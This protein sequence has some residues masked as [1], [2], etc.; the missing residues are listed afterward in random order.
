MINY[1]GS[2]PRDQELVF[3]AGQL[4][5]VDRCGSRPITDVEPPLI[6][7]TFGRQLVHSGC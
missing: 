1:S 7:A 6:N 5:F 4:Q 2:R 3:T